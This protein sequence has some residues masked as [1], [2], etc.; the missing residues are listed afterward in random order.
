MRPLSEFSSEAKAKAL[1][2]HLEVAG[3]ECQIREADEAF[4]VWVIEDD[5]LDDAQALLATF[6]PSADH[7]AAA[8]AIR[9]RRADAARPKPATQ[10]VMS[11]A[12]VSAGP[13]TLALIATSVVVG[14]ASGLGNTDSSVIRALLVVPIFEEN[15]S[16]MAPINMGW[17]EPWRL[18]TP[19][20]IHFGIFH[21]AF[22][23]LWLHRFGSQIEHIHG[24]V[25]FLAIVLVAQA[26]ASI[27]QFEL[28]GPLFGG[29][30]GVNYALFGFVWMQA[31]YGR[32]GYD[33]S[34]R[35]TALLMGWLLLCTT[36]LVGPV[37]NASHAVG[38]AVGL[39][40]GLPVYLRFRSQ[41]STKTSFDKGSWADLNIVGWRRFDKLYV[42]PYVPVWFMAIALFVLWLD[43]N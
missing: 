21:L 8:G 14:L 24:I 6:D 22:N 36:G 19:M 30:S 33:I 15:G 31:R 1:G 20:F 23:M 43:W 42:Q 26:L 16:L 28:T 12:T 18:L 27:L 25:R 35:D 5:L 10:R 32:G 3:I 37:A 13:L 39:L 38:L 4:S 29:M 9:S 2:D 17:E 7:S 34:S 40:V 41:H 11:G